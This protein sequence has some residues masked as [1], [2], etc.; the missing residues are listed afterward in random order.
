[1]TRFNNKSKMLNKYEHSKVYKLIN[2][3]ESLIY[4]GSTTK[5][6]E[7]RKKKH[8]INYLQWKNGKNNFV[9]S[10]KLFENDKNDVNICLIETFPCQTRRQLHE[11]ERFYIECHNCVNKVIPT[12]TYK[13]YH[14][15]NREKI[16]AHKKEFY[17]N[18]KD[19]WVEYR[20]NNEDR[21]IENRKQYYLKHRDEIKEKVKL[22]RENNAEKIATYKK[23]YVEINKDKVKSIKQKSY[24]KHKEFYQQEYVCE[25]GSKITQKSKIRHEKTQKHQKYINSN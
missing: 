6:L 12:R 7:Q 3:D 19:K 2:S 16:I 1:M 25:C 11:R 17:K 21:I 22:Y 14:E 24:E 15:D 10:F 20:E 4:I 8:L 18:N 5:T 13:E 23:A 9:T